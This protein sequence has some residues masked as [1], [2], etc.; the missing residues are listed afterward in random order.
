[1]LDVRRHGVNAVKVAVRMRRRQDR[2]SHPLAAA[3]LAERKPG[4]PFGRVKSRDDGYVIEPSRRQ[5]A[6]KRPHI[7]DVRRVAMRLREQAF[8]IRPFREA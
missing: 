4:A 3:Q 6:K 5:T 2:R 8:H 7:G 1:M